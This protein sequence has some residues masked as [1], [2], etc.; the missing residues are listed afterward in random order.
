[1]VDN[2]NVK[3]IKLK[4]L[5]SK[6]RIMLMTFPLLH[7]SMLFMTTLIRLLWTEVSVYRT[8]QIILIRFQFT[9][10]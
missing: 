2:I 7:L 4:S 8:T 1:M 5:S 6:A 10:R 3:N 9:G